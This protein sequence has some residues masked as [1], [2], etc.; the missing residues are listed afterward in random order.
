MNEAVVIVGYPASGKTTYSND[1]INQGYIHL[2]RDKLGGKN[3]NLVPKLEM[4]LEIK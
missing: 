3:K 2:N 4:K 1:L